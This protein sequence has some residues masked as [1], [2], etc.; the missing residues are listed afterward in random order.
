[1]EQLKSTS[2]PHSEWIIYRELKSFRLSQQNIE[3]LHWKLFKE[4][5]ISSFL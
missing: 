4:N 2:V 3:Y 1:M 5:E